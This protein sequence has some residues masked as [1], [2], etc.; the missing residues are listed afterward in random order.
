MKRWVKRIGLGLVA[1]GLVI[2]ASVGIYAKTQTSAFDD[3][4]SKAYDVPVPTNVKASTDP[5]VVL[6][7]KHLAESIMA[8]ATTDCHGADLSGGKTTKMGPL[9][10]ITGPNA[11][12]LATA[13]SDG[14]LARL[15]RHGVKKNGRGLLLMPSQ[16]I[17]WIS[18]DDLVALISWIRTVPPSPKANGPLEIGTLGKILDRKD[19]VPLDVARRIDH[20]HIE[21]A[22]PPAPTP[23]YGKFIARSC[24]GCHGEKLSGGPIPGAPSDFAV[25]LNL[26][27]HETGLKGYTYE[28]FDKILV[29]GTRRDGRKLDAFMPFEALAKGDDTEKRALYAYLMSAPPVPFGNR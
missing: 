20:A 4:L 1:L 24:T 17:N 10:T 18:D 8:C 11:S 15:V 9:A 7:G 16:D 26:T 14:E 13:Y 27:P 12:A 28:E 2:A 5:A 19:Q 23:A 29:T 25:P 22:P 3:S 6:R 21:L